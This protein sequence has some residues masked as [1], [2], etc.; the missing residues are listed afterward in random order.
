[1]QPTLAGIGGAGE[2]T[3]E[4]SNPGEAP[5]LMAGSGDDPQPQAT[6]TFE[7]MVEALREQGRKETE[8]ALLSGAGS[9]VCCAAPPHPALMSQGEEGISERESSPRPSLDPLP[10]QEYPAF[11]RLAITVRRVGRRILYAADCVLGWLLLP[12]FHPKI[13]LVT[14]AVLVLAL[15]FDDGSRED[16]TTR[17]AV[18]KVSRPV[19]ERA[20]FR[21]QENFEGDFNNW[22]NPSALAA[23]A[24]GT[25][26]V[27]GLALHNKTTGL[28]NYE[29]NL[30]ARIE[31]RSIG[32]VVRAAQSENYYAFKLSPSKGPAG[33]S[34][35]GSRGFDLV[36][37]PVVGGRTPA[38]SLWESAQV[39]I[40]AV[41]N[42]FLNIS[43]RVYEE[44]MMT[45]V[46]GFGVDTWRHAQF[47]TGGVG[48]LAEKGESF[49]VKSLSVSGNEDF[50]G[51]F[52][53]EAE[54]TI[55]TVGKN[56]TSLTASAMPVPAIYI[57]PRQPGFAYSS[58]L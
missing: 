4:F 32:W 45:V 51:L 46:N 19:R 12:V 33:S 29:M 37:Y 52:L 14:A 41:K 1:M 40:P 9:E 28:R 58:G 18:G 38:P 20:A 23:A 6:L 13:R 26:R 24:P 57:G 10:D 2:S 43:V 15:L 47:K 36:H 49:L 3:A 31:K 35:S 53:R 39:K 8:A 7:Q 21:Y 55:R 54:E 56:W 30:S 25:V 17:S 22:S 16:S 42:E 50:L 34:G 44:Q 48:L 5:V 27:R 11:S